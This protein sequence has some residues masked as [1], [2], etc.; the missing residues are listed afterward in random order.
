M[1]RPN[2]PRPRPRPVAQRVRAR[3]RA[4]EQYLCDM[5]TG[6][7]R[8]GA[9]N[10]TRL[11]A[12]HRAHSISFA[13]KCNSFHRP[14]ASVSAAAGHCVMRS[15]RNAHIMQCVCACAR[16]CGGH[17]VQLTSAVVTTSTTPNQIRWSA[18]LRNICAR[19]TGQCF[20]CRTNVRARASDSTTQ[21][22]AQRRRQLSLILMTCF[23]FA[24]HRSR[25]RA[26][27]RACSCGGQTY[28]THLNH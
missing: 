23:H 15:L 3:T 2:G 16:S 21:P 26:R 28:N 22:P 14:F 6:S 25:R 12:D 27:R 8:S 20:A 11:P 17:I 18:G 1:S 5:R 24:A 10:G 7:R 4:R 9:A 13:I 19:F